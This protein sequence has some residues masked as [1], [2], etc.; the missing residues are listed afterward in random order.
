MKLFIFGNWKM[1]KT[2]KES[3]DFVKDFLKGFEKDSRITV[4]IA[5]PFTSLYPLSQLLDG[6]G[7]ELTAQNMHFEEE[8]AFT[9]EIS[10][11]M[12]KELGCAYVILGHSERRRIFGEDD[13]FIN[14]KVASALNHGITPILCVGESLE[15]RESGKTFDV[16]KSQLE[17]GLDGVDPKKVVIAYEPVWAIGT[18]R[19]A[20]PSQA[21]EVHSFIKG[22]LGDI[23]VIYGGSVKPE[24]AYDLMKE[25]YVDGVLVGGASLKPESFLKIVGEGKRALG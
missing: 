5:P 6:K 11:K 23:P 17:K 10:P 13:A 24:N 16:V 12:I 1:H 22:I 9:G 21:D 20:T 3:M 8:G 19:N 2:P 15:E 4:G 14:K 25:K 7:V 18:G